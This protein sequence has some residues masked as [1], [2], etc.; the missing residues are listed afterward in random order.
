MKPTSKPIAP[1]AGHKTV[2][3]F[4]AELEASD[5]TIAEWARKHGHPLNT[6]YALCGKRFNGSR[7]AS[8]KVARAMGLQLPAMQKGAGAA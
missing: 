7:G 4:L 1:A 3:Q 5:M 8:R 6:V 2:E